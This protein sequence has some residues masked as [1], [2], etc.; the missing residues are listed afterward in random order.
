MVDMGG[1][2]ETETHRWFA[3]FAAADGANAAEQVQKNKAKHAALEAALLEKAAAEVRGNDGCVC[4]GGKGTGEAGRGGRDCARVGHI[5][6]RRPLLLQAGLTSDGAAAENFSLPPLAAKL[7]TE[8]ILEKDD[9]DML[10]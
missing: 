3:L 9:E 5:L 1:E 2:K 6:T 10:F 7:G 8:N 4:R